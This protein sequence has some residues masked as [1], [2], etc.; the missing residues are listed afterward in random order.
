M[1]SSY[2]DD[3]AHS[4]SFSGSASGYSTP[5]K[6]HRQGSNLPSNGHSSHEDEG[7]NYGTMSPMN[8]SQQ[9]M[10]P[11]MLQQTASSAGFQDQRLQQTA[12]SAGYPEQ[13]LQHTA[14]GVGHQ[15]QRLQQTA[16]S[17]GG[18]PDQ[19]PQSHLSRDSSSA[20]AQQDHRPSASSGGGYQS[21]QQQQ[22]Q[23]LPQQRQPTRS[24]ACFILDACF[25]L[26]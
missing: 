13:R 17:V 18:H 14:G 19:L 22:Q 3:S 2:L 16:S 15:E 6:P 21:Q 20:S 9:Q 4:S 7:V 11:P 24:L 25:G 1:S 23:Q 5:T 12:S 8:L 26:S 10:R